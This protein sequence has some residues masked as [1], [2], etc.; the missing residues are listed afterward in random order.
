MYDPARYMLPGKLTKSQNVDPKIV[1]I[2]T[3]QFNAMSL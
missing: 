1:T 3:G 2:G